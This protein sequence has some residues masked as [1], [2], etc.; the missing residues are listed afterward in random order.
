MSGHVPTLRPFH[1]ITAFIAQKDD[2]TL[3]LI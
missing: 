3:S 1:A 2:V